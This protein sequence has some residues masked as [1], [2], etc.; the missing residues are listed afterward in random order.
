[1]NNQKLDPELIRACGV[2]QSLINLGAII[3]ALSPDGREFTR[4][5]IESYLETLME[6]RKVGR[7]PLTDNQAQQLMQIGISILSM[8]NHEENNQ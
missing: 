1:M 2:V 6:E 4:Q 3:P 8:L 5:W 7:R